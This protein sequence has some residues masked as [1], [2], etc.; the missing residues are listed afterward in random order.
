MTKSPRTGPTEK[1]SDE[2]W[3]R[4]LPRAQWNAQEAAEV[5]Q[6]QRESGQRITTFAR[7]QGVNA[8]RLY[9][10]QSRLKLPPQNGTTSQPQGSAFIPVRVCPEPPEAMDVPTLNS[11][12]AVELLL[13]K[14]YRLR[15]GP[16]FCAQTLRR[17]LL[18]LTQEGPC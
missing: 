11:G 13:P 17:L 4:L 6:A 1:G 10:W 8:K 7:Q 16:A 5:L 18:M 14:G 9:K 12:G 15:L 3:R 2:R